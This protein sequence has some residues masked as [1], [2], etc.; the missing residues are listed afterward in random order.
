MAQLAE[1]AVE[2]AHAALKLRRTL[3]TENPTPVTNLEART[4]IEEEVAD[5]LLLL[6]LVGIPQDR[7]STWRAQGMKLE[8]WVKRLHSR[9][10]AQE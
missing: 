2:L 1:E 10:E 6:D 7:Q 8:R 4:N 5:V 9:E 3:S